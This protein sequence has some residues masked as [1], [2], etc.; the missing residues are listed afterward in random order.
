MS[1]EVP[2][3]LAKYIEHT[4]LKPDATRADIEN[5]CS[6]AIWH[7]FARVCVNSCWAKTA[8]SFLRN[9]NIRVA[10]V[11]GY[12]LGA[13]S[14]EAKASEAVRAVRDGARHID[15]V[16]NIGWAKEGVW[17]GVQSDIAEVVRA[18]SPWPV[19]VILETGLLTNDEITRACQ[20]AVQAGALYVQ[21]CTDFG[22]GSA[23]VEHIQLMVQA[24]NG[25]AWVKASG[26]V[27]D[28]ETARRMIAAGA[29]VIGTS[30]GVLFVTRDGAV[31]SPSY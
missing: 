21:T 1:G 29:D 20:V 14:T 23:T 7:H 25:Q 11:V 31:T 24:V 12:P 15:M 26:G 28:A 6:E 10:V 16:M 17:D 18:A 2:G 4:L 5:L 13:A 19:K 3:D 30:S 9:V 22:G 8:A 27:R